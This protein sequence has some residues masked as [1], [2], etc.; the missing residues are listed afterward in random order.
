M[1]NDPKH[2]EGRAA[3][4]RALAQTMS[5][6]ES[7]SA[8]LRIAADY[9]QIAKRAAERIRGSAVH[10]G[11]EPFGRHLPHNLV[12]TTH[13]HVWVFEPQQRPAA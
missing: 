4:A 9:D 13:S 12:Q 10:K 8:M 7:R 11:E 6:M 1:I 5:D 3:E 2:W